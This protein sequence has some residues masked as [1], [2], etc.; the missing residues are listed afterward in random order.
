MWV[1]AQADVVFTPNGVTGIRHHWV[2]DEAY[3]AYVT[4]GLDRNNDGQLTP[5][6]LQELANE[7]AASLNE[8]DYFATLKVKS[9][10]QAFGEPREARMV[11]EG[12]QVAMAFF[13]LLKT[14]ARPMATL[15]SKSTTRPYSSISAL[16]INR[17]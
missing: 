13:L 1:T 7:N 14:S 17:P 6:E 3:T 12:K 8:F 5:E 11:M 10:P 9:K 15:P 4:Q 2:F 16:R